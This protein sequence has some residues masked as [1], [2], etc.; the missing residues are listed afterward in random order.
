MCIEH[1]ITF[2]H[3]GHRDIIVEWC[4]AAKKSSKQHVRGKGLRQTTPVEKE[5]L[6]TACLERVERERVMLVRQDEEKQATEKEVRLR[7]AGAQLGNQD[8]N[9]ERRL[10]EQSEGQKRPISGAQE[11]F[12]TLGPDLDQD[13][14]ILRAK[15]KYQTGPVDPAQ[16]KQTRFENL[17]RR[18][19]GL[20]QANQQTP[21]RK[22]SANPYDILRFVKDQDDEHRLSKENREETKSK[23]QVDEREPRTR[24]S[25]KSTKDAS[26]LATIESQSTRQ[27]TNSRPSRFDLQEA[28][29]P[30]LSVSP[31]T[32][33]ENGFSTAVS[34]GAGHRSKPGRSER[35]E[36]GNTSPCASRKS[37]VDQMLQHASSRTI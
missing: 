12:H 8:K 19:F 4:I 27:E 9:Q 24:R 30:D 13:K 6:C 7:L 23:G 35:S 1:A 16:L 15:Q 14:R 18:L 34:R 21:Q 10:D 3:C 11:Q 33:A 29:R 26:R 22:R 5:G 36:P 37:T 20:P 25:L 32:T 31:P 28:H 2:F 17:Q